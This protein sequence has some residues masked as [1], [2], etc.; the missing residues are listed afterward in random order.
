[1]R[2]FRRGRPPRSVLERLSAAG[3][4]AFDWDGTL[5]D[6][7]GR[8]FATYRV[9]FAEL[10]VP[11]DEALFRRHQAPDWR[12]LY[13]AVGLP[14]ERWAEADHRWLALYESE[15]SSL[16]PGAREALETLRARRVPLALV[17]GGQ[18]RRVELELRANGLEGFFDA[19]VHGDEVPRRKPDPASMTLAGRYLHVDPRRLVMVGDHPDDMRMA[20]S[21]GALPIGVLSGTS[22]RRAL[23]AA[24][25][26]WTAESAE[27]VVRAALA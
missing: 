6:S 17:S 7:I 20:A 10:G 9:L 13:R 4:W 11:F 19:L 21:A 2:I 26:R 3:A 8:T 15:V 23:R 18:R 25:A 27:A 14:E 12:Q 16:L 1:M 22:D 24:G 5:L